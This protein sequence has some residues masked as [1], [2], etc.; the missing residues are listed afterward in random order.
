MQLLAQQLKVDLDSPT[1]LQ[2]LDG[3][4]SHETAQDGHRDLPHQHQFELDVLTCT[5]H[6]TTKL[7]YQWDA[8]VVGEFL[9][10][11]RIQFGEVEHQLHQVGYDVGVE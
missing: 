10:S 4:G 2:L 6:A 9:L 5:R 8:I 11:R 1:L 7:Q 3:S